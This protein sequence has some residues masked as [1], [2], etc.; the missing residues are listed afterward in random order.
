MEN[1]AVFFSKAKQYNS[2]IIFPEL[3]CLILYT[4]LK[5]SR[6][7]ECHCF[8]AKYILFNMD[9]FSLTNHIGR[10]WGSQGG[11]YEGGC[12]MGCSAV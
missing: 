4:V 6:Q 3:L 8:W 5:Y 10:I 12:L 9:I 2:F 7:K 1:A 11:D